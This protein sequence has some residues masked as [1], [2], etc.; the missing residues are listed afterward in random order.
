MKYGILLLLLSLSIQVTSAQ[1]ADIKKL[2]GLNEKWI[3][4]FVTR[5]TATMGSIYADDMELVSSRGKIFHKKHLLKNLLSRDQ[6]FTSYKVDNVSVRIFGN[7]G[8]V[9][10]TSTVHGKA[11]QKEFTVTNCYL[12]VYE[13]RKGRWYAVASQVGDTP[14]N[15]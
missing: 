12:D 8:L 4:S 3:A 15:Q 14:D 5:D 2:K 7:I 1:E 6:E 10:A 9:N 13:K 11:G